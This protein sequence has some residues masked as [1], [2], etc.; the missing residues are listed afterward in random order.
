MFSQGHTRPT[1]RLLPR[2]INAQYFKVCDQG[3]NN[4][5]Y[6]LNYKATK[7]LLQPQKNEMESS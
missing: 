6:G 3:I 1:S 2:I 7:G 5:I 4:E